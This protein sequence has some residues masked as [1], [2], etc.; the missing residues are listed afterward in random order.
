MNG[1]MTL[2]EKDKASPRSLLPEP[3]RVL[4]NR[5]DRFRELLPDIE[6]DCIKELAA[7]VTQVEVS[8]SNMKQLLESGCPPEIAVK[9]LKPL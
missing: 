7:A 4:W 9:I 3:E 5:F 1:V 8:P 2:I 6:E